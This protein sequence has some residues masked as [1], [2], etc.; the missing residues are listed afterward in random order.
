MPTISQN[1][2]STAQLLA[3]A[4]VLFELAACKTEEEPVHY[5]RLNVTTTRADDASASGPAANYSLVL[6]ALY[7]SRI[8]EQ[9][10]IEGGLALKVTALSDEVQLSFVGAEKGAPELTI[11]K[12]QFE[13]YS[14]TL[15]VKSA[16][17]TEFIV[18]VSISGL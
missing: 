8:E 16:T 7:G 18:A 15:D 3:A 5:D 13:H 14:T 4:V 9:V 17:G 2:R 1:M 12:D 11:T 6:P 10:G